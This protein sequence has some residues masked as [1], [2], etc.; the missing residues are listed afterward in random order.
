ML[1]VAKLKKDEIYTFKLSTGEEVLAKYK[2]EKDGHYHI[3]KPF[4]L[5]MTQDE[6]GQA[7]LGLAPFAATLNP[8]SNQEIPLNI[9]MVVT[10]FEPPKEIVTGYLERTS[11]IQLMK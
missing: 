2:D 10:F 8:T 9:N 4:V 7:S 6:K 1:K 5:A 3:V 11:G